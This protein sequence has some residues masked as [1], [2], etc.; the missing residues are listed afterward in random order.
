VKSRP[1]GCTIENVSVSLTGFNLTQLSYEC[2]KP[3]LNEA[4]RFTVLTL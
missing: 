2:D 1:L 4:N 3:V